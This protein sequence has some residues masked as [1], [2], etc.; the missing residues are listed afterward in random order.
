MDYHKLV[1]N[2]LNIGKSMYEVGAEVHRVEDSIL[3]M[4]HAYDCEYVETFVITNQITISTKFNGEIITIMKRVKISNVD[5]AR[6]DKLNNLSRLICSKKLNNEEIEDEY[7]KIINSVNKLKHILPLIGSVLCCAGFTVFFGGDFL[8]AIVAGLL[9]LIIVVI[10]QYLKPKMNQFIYSFLI[11]F[12]IGCLGIL[13]SKIGFGHNVDKVLIGTVMLIIPGMVITNS[14]RDIFLGD[15]I[16]GSL[17]IIESAILVFCISAGYCLSI[18]LLA[19]DMV[20]APSSNVEWWISIISCLIASYGVALTFNPSKKILIFSGIGTL[21][22][23]IAYHILNVYIDNPFII[24][25]I[26]ALIACT[27][28]EIMSRYAK[29]PAIALITVSLM[30][31]YPGSAFYYTCSYLVN[32]KY[33]EFTDSFIVTGYKLLGLVCGLVIISAAFKYIHRLITH[34]IENKRNKLEENKIN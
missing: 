16:T 27:L 29:T 2:I 32:E 4:L 12:I 1:E 24:T 21:L 33:S 14:F 18:Y 3:R 13:M 15:T 30:P 11:S 5:F 17:R 34:L 19:R 6:L 7:N 20:Q 28:S 8:D 26:P 22:A 9:G 31:F 10:N 25:F 23:L